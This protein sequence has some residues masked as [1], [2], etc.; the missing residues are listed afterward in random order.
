MEKKS[1]NLIHFIVSGKEF[2]VSEDVLKRRPN[3]RLGKL[4]S[5]P[6]RIDDDYSVFVPSDEWKNNEDTV[7]PSQVLQVGMKND[8]SYPC[9]KMTTV[10]YERPTEAFKAVLA[11]HQTG[12]LHMPTNMCPKLFGN[13]LK[14]WG[15]PVHEMENC[16]LY[17]YYAYLDDYEMKTAFHDSINKTSKTNVVT[18]KGHSKIKRYRMKI[19]TYLNYEDKSFMSKVGK[20][21]NVVAI[22]SSRKIERRLIKINL[23]NIVL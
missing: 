23:R 1:K 4:L 18:P 8:R 13:E 15:I 22:E 7:N 20:I 14:F 19:W 16:C 6:T 3:T 11:Y 12:Q 21:H 5:S 10:F 2:K 9:T 17:R